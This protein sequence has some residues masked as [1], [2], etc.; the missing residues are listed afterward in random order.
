MD[1]LNRF[2]DAG[3]AAWIFSDGSADQQAWLREQQLTLK[4]VALGPDNGPLHLRNW[5][6]SHP[7]LAPLADNLEVLLGIEFYRGYAIDGLDAAPLAT[8]DDGSSAI[9]EVVHDRRHFFVA[10]FTLNRDDTNWPTQVSFVPFIY[11]AAVWLAHDQAVMSGWRVGDTITLAGQ[12]AWSRLPPDSTAE[13]N[14]S[15]SVRPDAP[16]IYRYREAGHD[17]LYAVNLAAEESDLSPWKNPADF[18][19][20]TGHGATAPEPRTVSLNGSREEAESHQRIWWWLL[21]LATVLLLAE[22]RLANRTSI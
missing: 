11:S 15:G 21:A 5:D 3:G 18:L 13:A 19:A 1:R 17:R 22:L 8:W 12:G 20:L 2:L 9:A 16:G 10:G 7:L 4:P 6:T 14:V